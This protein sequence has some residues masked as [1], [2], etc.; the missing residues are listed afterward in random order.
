M[1]EKNKLSFDILTDADNA[2]AAQFGLRFKVAE[3]VKKVYQEKFGLDMEKFNGDPSWTLPMPARF[4]I[5]RDGRIRYSNADPD[6]TVR[7]EPS[8]TINALKELLR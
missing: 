6:Y 2:V 8:D 5:D 4:I 3:E 7:P 1:I